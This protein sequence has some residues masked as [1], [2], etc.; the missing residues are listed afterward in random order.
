MQTAANTIAAMNLT[1][2]QTGDLLSREWLLANRRGGFASGTLAG[3]NCRRYHGLLVGTQHPPANR[4]LALSNCLEN[5]TLEN[6][7][8]EFSCFEF[9]HTL[10]PHGNEYLTGF[11]L[12]IGAHFEYELGVAKLTKSVYLSPDSDTVILV[13]AFSN[14]VCPFSFS[15]RPLAALR[16]FH[17]LQHQSASFTSSADDSHSLRIECGT[18]PEVALHLHS[19]AMTFQPGAEWWHRFFYRIEQQRGQDCFEDL[20]SPGWYTGRIDYPETVVLSASLTA[21]DAPAG[22]DRPDPDAL[23]ESLKQLER[24]LCKHAHSRDPIQKALFLSAGQFVTERM[25]AGR[26][27]P[28]ILAGYPWFLDWGR[29]TFIALPGLCLSTGRLDTAAGVLRTF[30]G[31]VS[32]GMIPNRFDDY[33]GPPHYNS[34]DASLW[35]VHSAFAWLRESRD[36]A[37]FDEALLPAVRSIIDAYSA[38]TRFGIHADSDGLIT[39]GDHQTQ[40]TWMDAKCGDA[41][42][43][44]RY[45]KPVEINALWYNAL[46][47]LAA[48]YTE[49]GNAEAE[50]FQS[51][52][53]QVKK[54]FKNL[55]W[56]EQTG[57]LNDCVFPDGRA[58]ASIRPNQI[59]A[60]SLPHSPLSKTKQKRLV[61]I[62]GQELLTP[63]GLRTL[64]PRDPKYIGRYEG[65]LFRRDSAYHQ[66]TVWPW[67]MGGFIEAFLKV[68]DGNERARKQCAAMLAPLIHH[69][70]NN[71]CLA[72]ISEI[73]D[74]D[75]PHYPRGCPAQAWSV[76]EVL[77]AWRLIQKKD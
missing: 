45:G 15:V 6:D 19:P 51:L 27:T 46:C 75:P 22:M 64:S 29:D 40:L 31:A 62:V 60:V 57:C 12:D 25:V 10:H 30:A 4:I 5:I 58:D 56:N 50:Y 42:F 13:Y 16:D 70:A 67:L 43:T 18:A 35:F 41:V 14:L 44:P 21:K 32:E 1:G 74:G 48:Y 54:S 28:T 3:C 77:R 72:A 53:E 37:L 17:G 11:S 24:K 7:Q 20:W 38:G 34:M 71:A 8:L 9:E 66:G 26:R 63:Y 47:H 61:Q 65:D 69:F 33:G 73:F 55:F 52:A 36:R 76:A 59:F 39:G 49:Q 23:I 68:Y 2:L